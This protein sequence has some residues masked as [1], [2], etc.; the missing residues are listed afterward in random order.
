[1]H[2]ERS[3][4]CPEV[5]GTADARDGKVLKGRYPPPSH[6]NPAGRAR[7]PE[8]EVHNPVPNVGTGDPVRFRTSV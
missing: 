4:R 1:M 3:P 2:L 7:Q 6:V 8:T 5:T